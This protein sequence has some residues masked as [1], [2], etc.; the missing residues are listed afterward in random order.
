MAR[1][2]KSPTSATSPRA[3]L[4]FERTF[5]A[6]AVEGVWDLWT[7][8]AGLESWWGPERFVTKVSRLELRPGGKF[9]YAMTA[10]DSAQMEGLKAAGLPLTTVAG[11]TYV[12]VT[13]RTRLVY[14]TVA[15]FIHGVSPYEVVAVVE[16]HG[17]RCVGLCRLRT[18]ADHLVLVS[19]DYSAVQSP[20][21]N[22]Q[23]EADENPSIRGHREPEP[24]TPGQVGQ[25]ESVEQQEDHARRREP[26]VRPVHAS[27]RERG[28]PRVLLSDGPGHP[29][30]R[31]GEVAQEQHGT[32]DV[33]Q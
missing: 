15:D 10:T 2:S 18:H 1:K 16:V 4:T 17:K 32:E 6:A 9:E 31:H 29:G 11:G 24:S 22:E 27:G 23:S 14:R 30:R 33:Q 8:K 3:K 20:G 28:D 25:R 5:R 19:S 13:P 7:T 26:S 21:R 12:E